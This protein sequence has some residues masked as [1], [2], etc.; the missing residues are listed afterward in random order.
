MVL[1]RRTVSYSAVTTE[2]LQDQYTYTDKYPSD[3]QNGS[4]FTLELFLLKLYHVQHREQ[5]M[6]SSIPKY[7]IFTLGNNNYSLELLKDRTQFVSD[8]NGSTQDLYSNSPTSTQIL[9]Q[10]VLKF[11]F[12][13]VAPVF[14]K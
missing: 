13:V 9:H 14:C 2:H 12:G 1:Y 3:A 6:M 5:Y 7:Y 11:A 10:N 8:T 4:D